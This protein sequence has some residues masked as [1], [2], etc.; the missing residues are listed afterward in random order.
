MRKGIF[1][2]LIMSLVFNA[3]LAIS[4][5]H[6][7][8]ETVSAIL[9]PTKNLSLK[10]I[11]A[12]KLKGHADWV[13]SIAF[14]PDGKVLASASDDKTIILWNV[15]TGNKIK[16]FK[17]HGTACSFSPDGRLLASAKGNEIYLWD[18]EVGNKIK[19]LGGG[20]FAA[21]ITSLS[22]SPDGKILATAGGDNIILWDVKA[23]NKID[24]LKGPDTE[25]SISFS[26]DGN[27]L[28]SAND[29]K[30]IILWDV[31]T[32]NKINILKGHTDK[33]YSVSYSP[34]GRLLASA[35]KDNTIILWNTE[36]G[37]RIR[38][39]KSHLN[40]IWSVSFSSDG[41]LLASGSYDKKVII[42]DVET[43]N[44]LIVLDYPKE[45]KTVSFSPEG[46]TLVSGNKDSTVDLTILS[47]E[48]R[49]IKG[50]FES[51]REYE[52]RIKG[53]TFPYFFEMSL[54][55]YDADKGG[56][57][58]EVEG[59]K[60]FITVP[61]QK[62]VQLSGRKEKF[63]VE[64]KLRCL[65]P[66]TVELINPAMVDETTNENFAMSKVVDMPVVAPTPP[67]VAPVPPIK[68]K[69]RQPEKPAVIEE[70]LPPLRPDAFAVV[71][72]IDY[73]GRL[74]IPNL[75]YPSQ[76]AKKVYDILTDPRYGGVPV[77]N[78]ILLLNEK[79][80]RSEIISA[81]R[82]IKTWD[83]YI[84]VYYSGHG[85]PKT[86][87]DAF[88][89]GF[90]VPN[91]VVITDAKTMEQTSIKI[92]DLQEMI[93]SSQA[94]GVMVA[95]DACFSGGGK[96]IV[97][98]GAKPLVGIPVSPEL[99]KLSG[100]DKILIASSA[101]NEQSWEDE[102][103]QSGIFSHYLL[104]GLKGKASRDSWIK[105]DDLAK[106]IRDKVPMIARK[107]KGFEQT[108][109]VSGIGGFAVTRNWERT[110]MIIDVDVVRAKLKSAFE[111]EFITVEQLNRA[112]D[113][114]AAN[115]C[116]KILDA[117]ISGKIDEKKFGELY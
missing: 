84:Y 91:D 60:V 10:L 37:T 100:T 92:S 115:T 53:F 58:G 101:V 51:T 83:G 34:Y 94:K 109:Q 17:G 80:T 82:K 87:M 42:W 81:L 11:T 76:D 9:I 85:A 108:P 99:M 43:G 74:D 30:T 33:V 112:L 29:D 96:S 5:E 66:E 70:K 49:C 102:G 72:G 45:V 111:K 88:V 1:V 68:E 20:V 22:F 86:E 4:Q 7:E 90:L 59:N 57:T 103:L 6:T 27:I 114:L 113:E 77:E 95:L 35:G 75:Q 15:E 106:Y 23:G 93:E 28:A 19:T 47:E 25:W 62:A 38:S 56:F 73:R 105:A 116:S 107:L 69:V 104:E 63:R 78:A 117:F 48:R 79:A 41:K 12:K 110:K 18:I 13:T 46:K 52:K 98:K 64:G 39:L 89:D 54:G 16:V 8:D 65:S 14:R 26:P 32:G 3:N 31:D 2:L 71:I 67:L 50:E 21:N 55:K 24:T 44:K 40:E 97:P 61:P 36:T